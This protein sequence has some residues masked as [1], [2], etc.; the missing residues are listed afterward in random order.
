MKRYCGGTIVSVTLGNNLEEVIVIDVHQNALPV[1]TNPAVA[2]RA[3]V[4]IGA[5]I[6]E[7]DAAEPEGYYDPATQTWIG[8]RRLG[9]GSYSN[10]SN[11]SSGG[12]S[13]QSDD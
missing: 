9:L 7:P 8:G 13:Y 1:Q 5:A 2:A 4:M 12:Y 11:G 6:Q 10:R 3:F